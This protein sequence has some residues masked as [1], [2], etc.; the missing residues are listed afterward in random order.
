MSKRE[1]KRLTVIEQVLEKQITQK[2]AGT[3][4]TQDPCAV[5]GSP[6]PGIVSGGAW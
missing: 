6:Q 2:R 5:S 4:C 1:A 3:E